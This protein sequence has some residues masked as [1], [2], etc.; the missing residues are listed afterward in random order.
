MD[1]EGETRTVELGH[2]KR[3]DDDAD[4]GK[5]RERRKVDSRTE[6]IE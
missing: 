4:D 2:E 5:K 3:R 6:R 1:G